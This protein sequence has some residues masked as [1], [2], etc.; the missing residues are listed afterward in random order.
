MQE[1]E[2]RPERWRRE[3]AVIV[4]DNRWR[5][6]SVA[7]PPG[8]E[9]AATSREH[10]LDPLGLHAVRQGDYVAASRAKD[11]HWRSVAAAGA[12]AAV[13]DDAEARQ[14]PCERPREA[15]GEP[16]VEPRHP[17]AKKRCQ[18]K[19]SVIDRHEQRAWAR[20][21]SAIVDIAG[22]VVAPVTA[23]RP[24]DRPSRRNP[25]QRSK[26]AWGECDRRRRW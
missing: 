8:D 13:L 25:E 3:P 24:F 14:L 16:A 4:V 15:V 5:R 21:E 2:D 23:M 11:V 9:L 1:P 18:V 22:D 10:V 26:V 20:V 7:P 17:L 12:A 6:Q 19:T